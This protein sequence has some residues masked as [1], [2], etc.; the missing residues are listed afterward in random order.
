[1]SSSRSRWLASVRAHACGQACK[2][3]RHGLPPGLR[4]RL[5]QARTS[6]TAPHQ[7]LLLRQGLAVRSRPARRQAAYRHPLLPCASPPSRVE[8]LRPSPGVLWVSTGWWT[9]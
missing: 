1:M 2:S 5:L 6:A 8:A 7:V 9:A 3:A 4:T